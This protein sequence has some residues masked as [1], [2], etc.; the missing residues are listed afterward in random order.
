MAVET[1]DVEAMTPEDFAALVKRSSDSDLAA[2]IRQAGEERVL[3]R[4]FDTI[5]ERL[6]QSAAS[7]ID[8]TM[9]FRI[10]SGDTVYEHALTI[11]HGTCRHTV[12]APSDFR[13]G[14]TCDIVTFSK[15][16]TGQA[17]EITLFL[18][19]KLKIAG[20]LAFAQGFLRH[21]DRPRPEAAG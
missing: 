1:V 16:I 10:T 9:S 19:R 4:V 5:P 18:R 20:D 2:T 8:D 12:G 17:N 3:N 13:A 7:S 15:L 11:S 14:V 21:F 6:K